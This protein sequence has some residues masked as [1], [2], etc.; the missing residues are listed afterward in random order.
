[1]INESLEKRKIFTVDEVFTPAS[2]A[3]ACYVPRG[4]KVNDKVVNALKTRGKQIVV[5]GH[6]GSGK[7]TL[8]L[9]KLN[10]V[11]EDHL[12]SRCMKTTT[13][14][15][16]MLDA[17]SQLSPFYEV[18]RSNIEK[19]SVELQIESTFKERGLGSRAYRQLS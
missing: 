11:Y 9:N 3:I 15:I 1:M 16:L 6:S 10:Q 14:E 8:L 12:T 2:P 7:T 5:Y 19:K 17:I 4:E 18:E 13:V